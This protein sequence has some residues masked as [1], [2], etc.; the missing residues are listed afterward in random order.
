M[1]ADLILDLTGE[2]GSTH[3]VTDDFYGSRL[4]YTLVE[5]NL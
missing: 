2:P 1:R 3:A 5:L 4:A